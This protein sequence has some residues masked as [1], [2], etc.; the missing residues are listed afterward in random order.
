MGARNGGS[1]RVIPGKIQLH[2]VG[3]SVRLQV[4]PVRASVDC[5]RHS[6][7]PK[8]LKPNCAHSCDRMPLTR[9]DLADLPSRAKLGQTVGCSGF[10]RGAKPAPRRVADGERMNPPGRVARTRR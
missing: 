9:K 1:A 6:A 5:L 7:E 8:E 4:G 3:R 10:T 2:S